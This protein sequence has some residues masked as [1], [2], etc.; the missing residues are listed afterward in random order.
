MG[1]SCGER[2]GNVN[3]CLPPAKFVLPS[4]VSQS[5]FVAISFRVSYEE[6]MVC[7]VSV[8][9]PSLVVVALVVVFGVASFCSSFD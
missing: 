9:F 8:S 3:R 2:T 1:T 7:R 4:R 6:D 5:I